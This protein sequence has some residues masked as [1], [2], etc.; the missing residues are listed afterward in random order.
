MMSEPIF[1]DSDVI[2]YAFDSG[3][4]AKKERARE[5][6]APDQPW[7]ISWQVIQEFSNVALHKFKKP[8]DPDYLESLVDLL[9]WP[10][11]QILPNQ[12]IWAQALAVREQTRYRFYDSLIVAAAL[13]AGARTLYSEDLQDGRVIGDLTVVNPFSGLNP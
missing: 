10:H 2:A 4:P 1:F 7:I 8:L 12:T 9:L 6:I 13:Q 11:C 5:L 3:A